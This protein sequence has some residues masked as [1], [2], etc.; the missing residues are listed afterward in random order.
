MNT[1]ARLA[2]A[3]LGMLVFTASFAQEI[4]DDEADVLLTIERAW[5][6]NRKGD[7]DDFSDMLLD[8]FMGWAKTSPAPRSKTSTSRW[9][10]LNDEVG[11]VMRYELYPLWVTVQDDV[12]VAH[13]LYSV[14]VKNQDG[15]IEMSNGRYSD[16]LVRTDEGWKFMAWHGG[17]DD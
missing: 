17:K 14:A 11:R 1:P 2:V 8:N 5:E 13:Y 12:A 4:R 10:R 3:F 6:A 16:V 7:H 15:D 9:H